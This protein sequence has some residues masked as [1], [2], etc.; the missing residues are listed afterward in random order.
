[1]LYIVLILVLAA[2]GLVVAALITANSLWAWIS[3]GLSVL[4]GVL[5]VADWLRRRSSRT[6]VGGEGG[7]KAGRSE[8][9][10]ADD[11]T[12]TEGSEL[13]EDGAD[14]EEA[15]DS[16]DAENPDHSQSTKETDSTEAAEPGDTVIIGTAGADPGQQTALLAA[17]G[18]LKTPTG[19][20][21]E[22]QTDAADLLAISELDTEVLVVD[23]YP[24]YHLGHCAWLESRD[25]I[26]IAI[27]EARELGFTPCARCGPD[28]RIAGE[29]KGGKRTRKR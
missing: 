13:G 12:E 22:E 1:M 15:E 21:A 23:E 20:P 24:R 26:P 10:G 17:S 5:L 7:E 2:L 6:A 28:A 9:G 16:T 14:A 29:L 4:A 11:A 19:D 8:S 25:T 27:K 3:I 18:S